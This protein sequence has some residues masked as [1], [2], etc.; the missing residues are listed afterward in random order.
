MANKLSSS[1]INVVTVLNAVD[2]LDVANSATIT[3]FLEVPVGFPLSAKI[4]SMVNNKLLKADS[5]TED[6]NIV[7]NYS[8][9]KKGESKLLEDEADI[10]K[11]T[12]WRGLEER[13]TRAQTGLFAHTDVAPFADPFADGPAG[14]GNKNKKKKENKSMDALG[15]G[16]L[17]T[18]ID[19]T[20]QMMKFLKRLR[21][22]L[23]D[24]ID[25][26]DDEDE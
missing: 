16:S 19:E 3:E 7:W 6:N 9:T 8:L 4:R 24:F 18:V 5:N 12:E 17:A 10:Q 13:M 20:T 11:V 14:L 22:Q 23:E 15:I 2:C 25:D 21:A 26:E 1:I